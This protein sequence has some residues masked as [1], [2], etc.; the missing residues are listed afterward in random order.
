[1]APF[2]QKADGRAGF[3]VGMSAN[4]GPDNKVREKLV[5]SARSITRVLVHLP[6]K[7]H[8]NIGGVCQ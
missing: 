4:A 5:K 2:L 1:M 8:A 3:E 6:H 7:V